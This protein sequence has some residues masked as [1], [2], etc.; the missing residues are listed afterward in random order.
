MIRCLTSVLSFSCNREYIDT[1][2]PENKSIVQELFDEG[3]FEEETELSTKKSASAKKRKASLG[4]VLINQLQHFLAEKPF[5]LNFVQTKIENLIH[6]WYIEVFGDYTA[7]LID[8]RYGIPMG[9]EIDKMLPT[10]KQAR[11]RSEEQLKSTPRS[12]TKRTGRTDPPLS[13]PRRKGP[14]HATAQQS[15]DDD[16]FFDAKSDHDNT[17]QPAITQAELEELRKDRAALNTKHGNDPLAETLT[18]AAG[19]QG[20]ARKRNHDEVNGGDEDGNI[21]ER[22]SKL[23]EKKRSAI[24]LQFQDEIDEDEDDEPANVT[25][26]DLPNRAKG[27]GKSPARLPPDQGIF[28]PTGRVERRR[29]WTE[30]ETIALKEGVRTLG[31]GR[32]AN[33]KSD[34]EYILRN[35]TSVQIKDKWRTMKKNNE[36]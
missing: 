13:T 22:D 25:L 29:F 24:R 5:E 33:I 1:M 26:S 34:H 32:W 7:T 19:A 10:P 31:T 23:L 28:T 8:L 15:S 20:V 21:H 12:A 2:E 17:K 18:A 36:I 6:K 3:L 27:K 9:G 14:P 35:R 16:P 4:F 11:R 30:E